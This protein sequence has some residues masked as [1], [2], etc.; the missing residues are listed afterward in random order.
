MRAKAYQGPKA[1]GLHG[2]LETMFRPRNFAAGFV[3]LFLAG[4]IYNTYI[5]DDYKKKL[6][7][8]RHGKDMVE[9]W[10]NKATNRYEQPAPWDPT[11]RKLNP[12]L[13]LVPRD[14]VQR[15]TR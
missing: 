2:V 14:K 1:E 9:A 3:G 13:E 5:A 7:Q 10:Y 4:Y 6:Q 11:Y 8:Q 12:V 15:R